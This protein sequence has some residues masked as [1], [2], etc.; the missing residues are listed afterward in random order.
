MVIRPTRE[1][2]RSSGEIPKTCRA[3]HGSVGVL[4]TVSMGGPIRCRWGCS[5][6]ADHSCRV[7]TTRSRCRGRNRGTSMDS[8]VM[9]CGTPKRPWA[10]KDAPMDGAHS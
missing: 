5:A 3:G 4:A 8:T 2:T 6:A 9:T 10:P 7:P 1:I